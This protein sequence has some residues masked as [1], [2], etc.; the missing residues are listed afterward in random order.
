[1][2]ERP[3]KNSDSEAA[4][5]P[6][7]ER[8]SVKQ[9]ELAK[10]IPT[11]EYDPLDPS[12]NVL[13]RAG[14]A[15]LLLQIKATEKLLKNAAEDDKKLFPRVIW[16]SKTNEELAEENGGEIRVNYIENG[17]GMKIHFDYKAFCSILRER[18]LGIPKSDEDKE[19][20]DTKEVR[21]KSDETK[22]KKKNVDPCLNYLSGLGASEESQIR[23]RRAYSDSFFSIY[24]ERIGFFQH[25]KREEPNEY[26]QEK[27]DILWNAIAKD[28]GVEIQKSSRPNIYGNNFKGDSL[29]E[30]SG[31]ALLL[32][33]WSLASAFFKPVGLNIDKDRKTKQLIIEDEYRLAPVIVVPDVIHVRTFI[34]EIESSYSQ[35]L[36]TLISTPLES[37]LAFFLA[38]KLAHSSVL[39]PDIL[40]ARGA[41]VFAYKRPL[42]K[43]KPD[44]QRQPEVKG[45]FDAPLDDAILQQY[46]SLRNLRSQPY[47]AMR[48]RNLIAGRVWHHGFDALIEEYPLELFVSSQ[49][50]SSSWILHPK[51][52]ELTQ[53]V[54]ADFY[55]FANKENKMNDEETSIP[56][57]IDEIVSTY[58]SWRVYNRGQNPPTKDDVQKAFGKKKDDRT[59]TETDTYDAY[60]N[61]KADGIKKEFVDFRGAT[62]QLSFAELFIARLFEAGQ[63]TSSEQR[64]ML[65]PY[66]EGDKWE[67]GRWLVLMALS[68]ASV[69]K[70]GKKKPFTRPG[71]DKDPEDIY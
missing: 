36:S 10:S 12:L 46:Q 69:P 17:R 27:I 52:R 29:K 19:D 7:S 14:I 41:C 64:E 20:K 45:V 9:V 63:E 22:I 57:L 30:D 1:M 59:Q 15:G 47:K 11:L 18:Y 16:D 68:A 55:Y 35:S 38:P 70:P 28:T 37:P 53:D 42:K 65:R 8:K 62:D 34:G 2:A 39:T 33:F 32:H 44:Y 66:Y 51:A 3:A 49:Q 25:T 31:K 26:L 67:S 21:D 71:N 48:V 6:K 5:K 50:Q 23:V 40:G 24:Q 4:N 60:I 54:A 61:R 13:H 56:A 43:G 58:L